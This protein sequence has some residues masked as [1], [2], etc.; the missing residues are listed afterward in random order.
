MWPAVKARKRRR[1]PR[2]DVQWNSSSLAR[3]CGSTLLSV[4]IVHHEA[5]VNDSRNPAEQSQNDAEKKTGN[6]TGH[7]HRQRR[8]HHAEEIS[9]R[10]HFRFFVF[11]FCSW[12]LE[13]GRWA[14]GVFRP[15]APLA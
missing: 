11:A 8:Q 10:F 2:R 13:I 4:I 12:T 14:S 3:G 6:A 7:K 9:Q 1:T 5:S 15:L